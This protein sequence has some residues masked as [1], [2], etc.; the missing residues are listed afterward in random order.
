MA[1]TTAG[2]NFGGLSSAKTYQF[3]YDTSLSGP[4][5]P[6]P[7]RTNAV[8]AASEGDFNLMSAWFGGVRLDVD[9]PITVN[10]IPPTLPGAC[11]TPGACWSKSNR[12]LTVTVSDPNLNTINANIVRYLIVMEMVEQF[13]RAQNLGWFG[14]GTEGSEGEGLS[15]FLG[16]QF[17]AVNGIGSP[18]GNP[19]SNYLNSNLWMQTARADN[20]T[21]TQG[22]DDGPDAVTGCA[23][24]FIYYLSS[25][26][27]FDINAI[28]AAGSN[29]LGGV[30]KNLTND[31]SSP[32]L[33]F[34]QILDTAFPG[35][36]T[37]TSGNLDNPFPLPTARS[38]SLVRYLAA[39]PLQ[40]GETIK[41]RVRSK[42][43]GNLRAVLNSDRPASLIG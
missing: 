15:R 4:G 33:A 36:K 20:V 18:P 29:T 35:T 3:Q 5:G 22:T 31:T 24:L 13:E 32:F 14:S 28:I 40:G 9:T 12:S 25:E 23:L 37:I 7:S 16:G 30:Y 2:L 8:L 38:L 26:L 19:P 42:N 11:T 6:E 43:I 41:G 34:K 10:I 27:G 39:H 21:Q 17:L 1:T